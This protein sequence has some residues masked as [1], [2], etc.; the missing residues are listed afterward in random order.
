MTPQAPQPRRFP[1]PVYV[2]LFALIVLIAFLP[3]LSFASSF[4][5]IDMWHCDLNLSVSSTCDGGPPDAASWVQFLSY[6]FLYVFVTWPL[7]FLLA[8]VWLVVMLIHR[9]NFK[10]HN[11]A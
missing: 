3:V 1:W 7:A 10:R 11:P 9:A 4:F 6:S 2:I 8:I 5:L